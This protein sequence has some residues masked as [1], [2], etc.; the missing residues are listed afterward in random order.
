MVPV[1]VFIVTYLFLKRDKDKELDRDYNK[2]NYLLY[3]VPV[4]IVTI[5]VYYAIAVASGS[6]KPIFDRGSVV[7]VEQIRNNYDIIGIG[8]IIAYQVDNRIVIHRV[9]NI[10]TVDDEIYYYTKGML[11]L[12][13]MII[14]FLKRQ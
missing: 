12:L 2:T 9:T 8:Y 3:L 14:K 4:F 7:I 6:M 13:K 1:F 11:I 10:K 5:L